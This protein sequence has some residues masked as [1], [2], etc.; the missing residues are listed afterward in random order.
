MYDKGLLFSAHG[1]DG[2]CKSIQTQKCLLLEN[3][4]PGAVAHTIE[5]A[6]LKGHVY[7]V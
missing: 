3:L 1:V 2:P 6:A 7:K 4:M 5:D